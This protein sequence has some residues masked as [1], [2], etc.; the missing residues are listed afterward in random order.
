M[1]DRYEGLMAAGSELDDLLAHGADKARKQTRPV[2]ER[3]R[4]A[5]GIG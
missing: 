3:V 4:D 1:R 2:L 5:I